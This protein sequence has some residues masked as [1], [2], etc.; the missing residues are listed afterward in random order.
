[1]AKLLAKA[2]SSKLSE[3]TNNSQS[4]AVA[5]SHEK[6]PSALIKTYKSHPRS[7]RFDPET[8]N[9]LQAT[10][11]RVNELSAKKISEA[12]LVKALI[13][14]SKDVDEMKIIKASK[15]VW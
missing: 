4:D 14:L 15:E 10:L 3:M 11:D 13:F 9:I 12:K 7:Y 6:K 5:L 8:V 1:M 2:K